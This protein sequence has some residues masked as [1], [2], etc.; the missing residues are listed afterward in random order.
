MSPTLDYTK[1]GSK[2][3]S[4]NC[5]SCKIRNYTERKPNSI[6]SKLWRWHTKWCPGWKAY[7]R[8]LAK[9]RDEPTASSP[10]L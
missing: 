6:I 9:Q 8:E 2:K 5:E 7:Q 4:S 1:E 10:K 3:M